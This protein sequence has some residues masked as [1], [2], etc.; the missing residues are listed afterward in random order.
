MVTRT[1]AAQA[2]PSVDWCGW[3]PVG[4]PRAERRV[5]RV[6]RPAQATYSVG[7][8]D[9]GTATHIG[10]VVDGIEVARMPVDEY[11]RLH[12][13]GRKQYFDG[14]D[15]PVRINSVPNVL[16]NHAKHREYAD[17]LKLFII[18]GVKD[19]FI[20]YFVTVFDGANTLIEGETVHEFA[21]RIKA[22]PAGGPYARLANRYSSEL[23][24]RL[25]PRNYQTLQGVLDR[26]LNERERAHAASVGLPPISCAAL[27]E[28]LI[29]WMGEH[30]VTRTKAVV[31]ALLGLLLLLYWLSPSAPTARRAQ[32]GSRGRPSAIAQDESQPRAAQP[33]AGP[34]R[35]R[36]SADRTRTMRQG[37]ASRSG[38]PAVAPGAAFDPDG[39]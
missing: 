32:S 4:R 18:K 37:A 12:E 13:S 23:W 21:E 7:L 19:N 2:P 16:R 8:T 38:T 15:G 6:R 22:E 36:L 24:R 11:R 27:R 20:T 14:V 3:A 35:A 1:I 26:K 39:P 29:R 28:G 25:P 17:H 10:V 31:M 34:A 5:H 9:E 33:P 30:P